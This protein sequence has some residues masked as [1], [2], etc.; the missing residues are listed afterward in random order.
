MSSSNS[1]RRFLAQPLGIF[2]MVRN[3]MQTNPRTG[4][5]AMM[6]SSFVVI[7]LVGNGADK[8]VTNKGLGARYERYRRINRMLIPYAVADYRYAMPDLKQ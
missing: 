7:L 5:Y 4:N 6:M 8:M 2:D 1:L 3:T